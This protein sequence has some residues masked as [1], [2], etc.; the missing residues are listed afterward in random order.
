MNITAK[1]KFVKTPEGY[2]AIRQD[3][4]QVYGSTSARRE[5]FRR[6]GHQQRAAEEVR[7]DLWPEI[8]L[9]GFQF[10]SGKLAAAGQFVPQEIIAQ[11]GWLAVGYGRAKASS[12]A[13]GRERGQG[14]ALKRK[15]PPARNR[16][17][18]D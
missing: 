11:E 8:K 16:R 5:A 3:D 6:R 17:I 2:K 13:D 7:Q 4:L 14:G 12:G 18:R 10:N 15:S 1:Y 9:Q